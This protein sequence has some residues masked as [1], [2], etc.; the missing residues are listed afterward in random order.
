MGTVSSQACSNVRDA[1]VNKR[2][3]EHKGWASNTEREMGRDRRVG[4]QKEIT[5]TCWCNA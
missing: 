4:G 3:T 2:V 5:N 1:L